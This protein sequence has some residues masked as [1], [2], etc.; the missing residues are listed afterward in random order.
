MHKC[1]NFS[2]EYISTSFAGLLYFVYRFQT[3]AKELQSK[4]RDNLNQPMDIALYW[5]E[6]VLR[7]KGAKHLR[8][9]TARELNFVQYYSIDSM[10][11]VLIIIFMV[12]KI[13]CCILRACC[14]FTSKTS[15]SN[16]KL[17]FTNKK[18]NM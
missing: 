13:S 12:L 4:F 15:R 3:D 2:P 1:L 7:H 14:K 17:I 18:K 6:Y 11:I 5:T 9:K 10:F 8:S 16:N